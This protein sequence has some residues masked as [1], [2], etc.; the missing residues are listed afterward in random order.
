MPMNSRH[1][2]ILLFI[3]LAGTLRA[4]TPVK[5]VGAVDLAR[6]AG[7]WFEIAS[8]PMFFQRNCIGDTTADYA[9]TPEG[10]DLRSCGPDCQPFTADDVLSDLQ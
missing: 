9:L 6:Y 8:F 4:E 2:F 1:L 5:G 7:K 3:T 10:P